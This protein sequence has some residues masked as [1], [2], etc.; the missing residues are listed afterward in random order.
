MLRQVIKSVLLLEPVTPVTS[1][2]AAAGA[3]PS[4]SSSPPTPAPTPKTITLCYNPCFPQ[5]R[6]N[7]LYQ[8][9]ILDVIIPEVSPAFRNIYRRCLHA[10][11]A[12]FFFF[13]WPGWVAGAAGSTPGPAVWMRPP[14][15]VRPVTG[16]RARL[17][18]NRPG[19]LWGPFARRHSGLSH[20]RRLFLTGALLVPRPLV[21]P[22]CLSHLVEQ[23]PWPDPAFTFDLHSYSLCVWVLGLLNLDVFCG[24]WG[25]VHILYSQH[26]L[27]R[28]PFKIDYSA[29]RFSTGC[30][31]F[32]SSSCC[33]VGYSRLLFAVR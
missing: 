23:R 2:C 27:Q 11:T 3:W 29:A 22:C 16:N 9:Y 18:G 7:H 1:V 15:G 13:D 20:R 21:E 25:H 24:H 31:I 14:S 33:C 10:L 17:S 30:F 6:T 28:P 19:L 5:T 8:G 4:S 26:S 12:L 32:Q